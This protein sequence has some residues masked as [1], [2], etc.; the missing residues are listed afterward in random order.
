MI[1]EDIHDESG[2]A[3]VRHQLAWLSFKKK[4]MERLRKL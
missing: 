2:D 1:K 4:R 3:G